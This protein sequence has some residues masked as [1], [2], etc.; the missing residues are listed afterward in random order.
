MNKLFLILITLLFS[1]SAFAADSG[2]ISFTKK[3]I[4]FFKWGT[5]K[6]EVKLVKTEEENIIHGTDEGGKGI[7]TDGHIL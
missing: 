3:E 7:L 6:N 2:P 5:G 1:A 4:A